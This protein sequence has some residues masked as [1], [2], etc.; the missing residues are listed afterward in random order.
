MRLR[1]FHWS[2][3]PAAPVAAGRARA[4]VAAGVL[5]LSALALQ[6]SPA[7]ADGRRAQVGVQLSAPGVAVQ[8]RTPG[9][10]HPGHRHAPVRHYVPHRYAASP[11]VRFGAT[12]HVGPP[13]VWGPAWVA[14]TYGVP[15]HYAPFHGPYWSAPVYPQVVPVPV[16]PPVYIERADQ[17][18]AEASL[19]PQ[20]E[21]S[22]AQGWWYWCANPEGFHPDVAD[23]PGGWQPV[24]PRPQDAR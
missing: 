9:R 19:A 6:A 21:G 4:F 1:R 24:A 16:E 23:C 12:V 22:A 10:V 15:Y 2:A 17:V 13:V 18:G 5:A 14:P 11:R 20:P 3:A 8:Y 7:Q